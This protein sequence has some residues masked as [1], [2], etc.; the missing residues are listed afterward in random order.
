M[1]DI[2]KRAPGF[3]AF[4]QRPLKHPEMLIPG[5]QA[6]GKHILI[7]RPKVGKS[8]GGLQHCQALVEGAPL[9]G[10]PEPEKKWC[11]L[12]VSMD[13]PS[14]DF[15]MQGK[16]LGITGDF[17]FASWDEEDPDWYIPKYVLDDPKNT[18]ENI[19]IAQ[20]LLKRYQPEV[21]LW[22][23]LTVM[24]S[25]RNFNEATAAKSIYAAIHQ[26]LFRGPQIIIAHANKGASDGMDARHATERLSG[27][28]AFI[29]DA[30]SYILMEGEGQTGTF[31]IGGRG[32]R[33]QVIPMTRGE[34]GLWIRKTEI[35][36]PKF[37]L[38]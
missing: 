3:Q 14:T 38:E 11:V 29:A 35:A 28:H 22:D 23:C 30:S 21:V 1:S 7:G 36:R 16:A 17:G 8:I 33:D 27:S 20:R 13:A 10:F 26:Y 32:V 4:L 5:L 24:D 37:K 6:S 18:K 25:T 9:W 15:Q 2:V 12:Y 31:Q 34:G 19:I